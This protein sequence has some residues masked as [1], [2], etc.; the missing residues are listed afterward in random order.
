MVIQYYGGGTFRIQSGETSLLVDSSNN[1]MKADVSLRTLVPADLK[2]VDPEEVAF[3]GEYEA[4]GIEIEGWGLASESTAKFLKSVYSVRME[5]IRIVLLGHA[6]K[7]PPTEVL[8]AA[9]DPDVLILPVGDHFF[10]ATDAAKL[11]K[12]LE[13]AAVIPSF[14]KSTAE[15]SKALGQKAEPQEKFVFKKK[16][17]VEGQ[18]R[19]LILKANI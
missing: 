8:E 7:I 13:P 19:L 6:S 1:R 17:L 3:P 11:V 18:E 14:Y 16:D 5:D 15:V 9:G 10:S 12:Q 2:D 4:H